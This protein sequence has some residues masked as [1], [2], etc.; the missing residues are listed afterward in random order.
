MSS[1]PSASRTHRLLPFILL[2]TLAMIWGS[3]FILMKRG[4]AAFAPLQVAALRMCIA[5]VCLLPFALAA[6]K[7][8]NASE[9]RRYWKPIVG[10]GMAGS[11]VPAALFCFAQ[12]QLN[13]STAGLL[14]SLSPLFTLIVGTLL[15]Q[16]KPNKFQT[17]GV[18]TGLV[19]AVTLITAASS[20]APSGNPVY[21]LLIVVATLCYGFSV[22]ITA[23]HLQ[24]LQP[25]QINSLSL[26]AIVLPYAAY[27]A[28][29]DFATRLHTTP[30]AWQA[31]GF[32]AILAS[33]G[34]AFSNIVFTKLIKASSPIFAS[35][36]TYLI[37]IVALLWGVIDGERLTVLH[38]AGIVVIFVG[39]M[40]VNRKS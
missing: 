7:T 22:N 31:L 15:F 35:S 1:E 9:R 17:F 2:A 14:N 20:E 6:L 28:L 23:R 38:G 11:A 19:G 12:T 29:S 40:L 24:G 4:L 37:P 30:G 21:G 13:S 26:L 25:Q 39:I 18:L 5:T 3:S 34:T 10:V 27:L 8:L 32:V 16:L 36:V 33:L